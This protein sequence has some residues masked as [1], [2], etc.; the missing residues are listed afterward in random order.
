MAIKDELLQ[1]GYS[2]IGEEEDNCTKKPDKNL[3]RFKIFLNNKTCTINITMWFGTTVDVPCAETQFPEPDDA[4]Y[5]LNAVDRK[6]LGI[7]IMSAGIFEDPTKRN[8]RVYIKD[9]FEILS[10]EY[11]VYKKIFSK[12]E[13]LHLLLKNLQMFISNYQHPNL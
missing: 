10:E 8:Y 11:R 9:D 6:N 2:W 4:T 7:T 13:N 3:C 5:R 1:I 12:E